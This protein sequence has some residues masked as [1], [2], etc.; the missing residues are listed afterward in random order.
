M[1]PADLHF[2]SHLVTEPNAC[3]SVSLLGFLLLLFLEEASLAFGA[4]EC[5]TAHGELSWF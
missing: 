2:S 1:L 3:A 5:N 4:F